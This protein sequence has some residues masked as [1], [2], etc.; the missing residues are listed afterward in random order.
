M[1]GVVLNRYIFWW[2]MT[3]ADND[4]GSGGGRCFVMGAKLLI[5]RRSYIN[6]Q[7]KKYISV[8]RYILKNTYKLLSPLTITQ[9][10]SIPDS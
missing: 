5:R 10:H 3:G 8:G 6:K 2:Y 9:Q 7:K 4:A 1:L